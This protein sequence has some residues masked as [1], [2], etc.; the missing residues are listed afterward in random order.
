METTDPRLTYALEQEAAA[1]E[2]FDRWKGYIQRAEADGDR[3]G[4]LD[5]MRETLERCQAK[6]GATVGH[7]EKIQAK[8]LMD[9]TELAPPAIDAEL[10]EAMERAQ[11]IEMRLNGYRKQLKKRGGPGAPQTDYIV[12]AIERDEGELEKWK[13]AGDRYEAEYDRRG[14][15]QRY[16]LVTGGRGHLHYATCHTLTPGKTWI[17]LMAEASGMTEDEVVERFNYTACTHC[18]KA[19][20]VEKDEDVVADAKAKGYCERFGDNGYLTAA[21]RDHMDRERPGWQRL[22]RV[23]ARCETCGG[24]P[25]VT[26]TGKFRKHKVG[27]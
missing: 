24:Y 6:L 16:V 20:P 4:D 23:Y 17:G 27:A 14:G 7:R 11:G 12:E 22:Y 15:W 21:E 9:L 3:D 2:D 13:H 25:T 10:F 19:A 1:Q 26:T 18:F 5:R 8:L